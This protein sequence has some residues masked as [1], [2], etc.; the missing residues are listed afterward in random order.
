MMF[1]G[2]ICCSGGL[3]AKKIM[4]KIVATNVVASRPPNGD[5]LQRR[6]L[7]PILTKVAAENEHPTE[8]KIEHEEVSYRENRKDDDSNQDIAEK[9]EK[10]RECSR[11]GPP[12][13]KIELC[14]LGL[15]VVALF[16]SMT[17]KKTGEILRKVK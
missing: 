9:G 6:P 11:C 1:R 13:E 17:S 15:D 12:V 10:D 8:E 7:V 14:L 16:P 2:V 5:R 3:Y 4:M